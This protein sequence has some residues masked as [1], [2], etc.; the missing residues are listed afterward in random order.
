MLFPYKIFSEVNSQINLGPQYADWKPLLL[1]FTFW[2][3]ILSAELTIDNIINSDNCK[4]AKLLV[5]YK[6]YESK[7]KSQHRIYCFLQ[8]NEVKV[9]WKY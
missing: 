7:K 8:Y 1:I 9:K 4:Q 2:N 5:S 3:T 6:K